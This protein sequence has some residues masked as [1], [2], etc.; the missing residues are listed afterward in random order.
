M[1]ENIVYPIPQEMK[2]TGKPFAL[3]DAAIVI[4]RD[5]GRLVESAAQL[6]SAWLADECLASV[7]VV[8]GQVPA[9]V[10]PIRL[11]IR[12]RTGQGL[13]DVPPKPEGYAL[14]VTPT[15][16]QAIGA[17]RQGLLYAVATILQLT[18]R[19]EGAFFV[20]GAEIRD[21]PYR[22]IRY[23]HLYVPSRENIPYF[24]RYVRD[25]LLRHKFNG[26]ILEIGGGVLLPNR[27]E[28]ATS[29]RRTTMELY[30]HGEQIHKTGESCPLGPKNRFQ[31]TTHHGVGDGS[32]I[33]P[34]ELRDLV[35][36]AR[37][38][39]QDVVPEIQSYSHVYYLG[40]SHREIA[41]LPNA[42][43]PDAYCPSN[44]KSYQVLFD[45]LDECIRLMKPRNVHIGHDEL[46]AAGLC[47]RCRG[48]DLGS[49]F[50]RDVI[51]I[52]RHLA[53]QNV[54]T[55]MWGDHFVWGHNE[56]GRTGGKKILFDYP[57]T[58][59]AWRSVVAA[60]PDLVVLNWS[61]GLRP[62]PSLPADQC[63]RELHDKGFGFMYGN[64]SGQHFADWPGRSK[65]YNVLG[66]EVFSWCTMNEFQVGKMHMPAALGSINL[67]WST[68]WEDPEATARQVLSMLPQ[69]RS[70]LNGSHRPDVRVTPP[71]RRVLD[72]SKA[73]N[74][75]LR[76]KGWDLTGLRTGRMT[77]DGLPC[78]FGESCIVVRRPHVR[79]PHPLQVEMPVNA[80]FA[81]LDFV[82]SA[83]SEG[84]P[85]IH[86]GDGT[87]FPLESSELIGLYEIAFHDGLAMTQEIRYQENVSRWD[88][89]LR[90]G[91]LYHARGIEAGR[92]PD[93]SPLVV[94]AVR[95]VN[96]RPDE[97]IASVRFRGTGGQ[98]G[99]A[100]SS[101]PILLAITG[102]GKD[103]LSDFR[104]PIL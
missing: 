74:S 87:F 60:C 8:R 101:L 103:R 73:C 13:L 21:W 42:L 88:A 3:R 7:R 49:L 5:A 38:H 51:R 98:A 16:I 35:A 93:G 53:R 67:L 10:R 14:S 9:G 82:H 22:K 34:Q 37:D 91:L 90:E 52:Y 24:K 41:E 46:R 95:W 72:L 58:Q 80:R 79:S 28:I 78:R 66:G 15:G 76:G 83:T 29:W 85:N 44:P 43:F 71:R 89:G 77:I 63:D 70:R 69:L 57:P 19:R 25:V 39:G 2:L 36:F 45:V 55:W 96:P 61:W 17:D 1:Q 30:A 50:A 68:H 4:P 54:G 81:C 20:R 33:L 23:V 99:G 84:R 40:C 47:P 26:I 100:S 65:R 12:S 94:W 102:T 97:A 18:E 104:G 59:G 6:L 32:Y 86:A 31:D 92:L 75:P 56:R 64:F 62:D 27:P 11:A 48:K